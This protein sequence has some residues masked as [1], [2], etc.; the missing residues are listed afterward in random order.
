M[1][2]SVRFGGVVFL[3]RPN[4]N[5]S[6]GVRRGLKLIAVGYLL[7][8][9]RSTLPSL[10]EGP[11]TWLPTASASPL[12]SFWV[13]DILQMAGL[14]LILLTAVRIYMPMRSAW[15]IMAAGIALA[16]PL[17]LAL[18]RWLRCVWP[19]GWGRSRLLFPPPLDYLSSCRHG[20]QPSRAGGKAP[21]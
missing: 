6:H 4:R 3:G 16:S 1:A 14:S 7:N 17:F 20:V 5:I 18:G 11:E 2:R 10:V 9:V 12:A 21:W 13:V 8:L 19:L 15:T